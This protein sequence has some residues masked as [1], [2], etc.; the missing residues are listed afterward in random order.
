MNLTAAPIQVPYAQYQER[1]G[2]A[3]RFTGD[4]AIAHSQRRWQSLQA[5]GPIRRSLLAF[6]RSGNVD[7]RDYFSSITGLDVGFLA[8]NFQAP[9]ELE[10][11]F[12][13][14]GDFVA[15]QRACGASN[16]RT[17]RANSGCRS[18]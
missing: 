4:D 11:Y 7:E 5:V 2:Q 12:L 6:R 8:P 17:S 18:A 1:L 16:D 9:A 15:G 10:N 3:V 14:S 13:P